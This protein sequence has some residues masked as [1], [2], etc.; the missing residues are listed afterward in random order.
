MR[1][2]AEGGMVAASAE[3]GLPSWL[4][5]PRSGLY[6]MVTISVVLNHAPPDCDGECVRDRVRCEDRGITRSGGGSIGG[7]NENASG[8][9]FILDNLTLNKNSNITL[10]FRKT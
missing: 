2:I 10:I 8:N 5:S 7:Y 6:R 9:V 1:S 4:R 3:V